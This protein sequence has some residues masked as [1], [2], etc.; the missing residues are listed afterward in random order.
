MKNKDLLEKLS[1]NNKSAWLKLNHKNIFKFSEQYKEFLRNAKTERESAEAILKILKKNKF[2]DIN[3][4]KKLKT[5]DKFFLNFKGKLIAAGIVG[6]KINKFKIIGSHIDSP[7]LDLKPNPIYEDSELALFKSHYYGGIKKYQWVNTP[8]EMHGVLFTKTKKI[9][10]KDL[11]VYFTI[12]DLLPHLATKQMEKKA[13]QVVEGEEMNILIGNIPIDDKEIKEQIKFSILKML[14]EKYKITE[15]DFITAEI[16]F[17]PRN[18]PLDI[19]FDKSM[20][21]AYGHDD[22]VCAYTS[23]MALCD[24]KIPEETALTLFVDKEEIGSV[25]D[26]GAESFFLMNLTSL[27]KEKTGIKDELILQNAK[28]VSAD[29]TAAMN[30]N[31]KDANDPKNVSYLGRGVS[32]EK[33]GGSYGK[34]YSNDASAEYMA[35][36]RRILDKNKIPWQTGELG[37]IDLGGGGTIAM[38]LSR[39]GMD[40]VDAGPSVLGMHSPFE[41]VSKADVYS[42]FLFYRAFLNEKD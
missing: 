39:Y 3:T 36:I 33:Y 13:K 7:R 31:F 6:R 24:L 9:E 25:G 29:V 26:T 20:L 27:F 38:F 18:E 30:P 32:V 40:C 8:L 12:P 22:K 19:G 10:F 4:I 41:V 15:E 2:N 17:V 35:Y 16:E 21:G 28:A 42:A 5:G 23:L 34:F 1:L 11:D 14:N 37:K